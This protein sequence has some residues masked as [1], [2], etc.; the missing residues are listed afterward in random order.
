MK[1]IYVVILSS[2]YI[3]CADKAQAR[4]T[5]KEYPGSYCIHTRAAEGNYYHGRSKVVKF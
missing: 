5:V 4:E 2:G 3:K 1:K